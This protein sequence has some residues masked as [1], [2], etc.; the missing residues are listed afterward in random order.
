MP[1]RKVFKKRV[2]TKRHFKR[3]FYERFD[4]DLSQSEIRDIEERIKRKDRCKLIENLTLTKSMWD[5]EIRG[6]WYTIIYSKKH[7]TPIT[8]YYGENDLHEEY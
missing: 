5:V 3:R 4:L 7:K 2:H 8:V 6:L 1:S